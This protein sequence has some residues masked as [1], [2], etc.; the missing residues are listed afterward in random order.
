MIYY[1]N[2]EEDLYTLA[3]FVVEQ[4]YNHHAT[5][6]PENLCEEIDSVY[7]EEYSLTN[8]KVFI[9]STSENQI[10]GSI[11]V[12]KWNFIDCLP[13]KSVFDIDPLSL[14]EGKEIYH[15]GRFAIKGGGE[16]SGFKVFKTLMTYAIN[17]VCKTPGSFALAEC[18]A[19]LLNIIKLLGIEV[20]ILA[21]SKFYLGSETIPVLLSYSSLRNFLSKNKELIKQDYKNYTFA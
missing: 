6:E 12:L 8:S 2:L 20:K 16:N 21:E 7:R 15:I 10:I 17:E 9:A 5:V 11:R 14:Y 19:K 1:S 18:D 13:I 4:N 3:K